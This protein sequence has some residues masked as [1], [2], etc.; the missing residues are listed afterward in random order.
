[1]DCE[2]LRVAKAIIIK[3]TDTSSHTHYYMLYEFYN[4]FVT[5]DKN[6]K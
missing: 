5:S 4:A 6:Y 2:L 3:I 1:M